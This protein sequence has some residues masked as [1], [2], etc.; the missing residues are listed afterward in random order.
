MTIQS[1]DV[2][3]FE[4]KEIRIPEMPV[5]SSSILKNENV[6]CKLSVDFSAKKIVGWFIDDQGIEKISRVS[7]I[8]MQ[9]KS[10]DVSLVNIETLS[11]NNEKS[12]R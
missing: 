10:A 2:L 1:G 8:R 5:E 7:L 6:D 11:F 12:I 4:G 3:R 9:F